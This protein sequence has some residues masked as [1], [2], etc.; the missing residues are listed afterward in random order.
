MQI[1]HFKTDK[2]LWK[3]LALVVF[4]AF[5]FIPLMPFAFGFVPPGVFWITLFRAPFYHDIS[6][7]KFFDGLPDVLLILL[8]FSLLFSIPA[9]AIGWVLQCLVV[10]V[11]QMKRDRHDHAA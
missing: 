9:L 7:S 3:H 1:K 10:I 8:G 4:V 6:W 2:R 5:W 11:R